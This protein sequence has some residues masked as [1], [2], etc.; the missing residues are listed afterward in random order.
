[1]T[2]QRPAPTV[3]AADMWFEDFEVGRT[4]ISPTRTL[5][6]EEIISFGKSYA[7]LPYHTDPAAAAETAFGGLVAAGYQTVALTFGLYVET[8]VLRACGMGSPGADKLRWH[9]P[10][11]AGDTLHVEA[12]VLEVSPAKQDGGRD[13][14]R[15]Q[16]ET[17]NQDGEKVL[18]LVS[19]HFVRRRPTDR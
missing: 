17:F 14:I 19:L 2:Y 3:L 16:Y 12:T 4:F 11:F 6:E 1:M 8:G 13:A 9:K 7:D 18:T 5:S 15:M 10:V